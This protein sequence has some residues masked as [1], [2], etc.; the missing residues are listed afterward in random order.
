MPTVRTVATG[1][2]LPHGVADRSAASTETVTQVERL[3]PP[4]V[5]DPDPAVDV[6]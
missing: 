2:R 3:R 5:R 6:G 1:K 4:V